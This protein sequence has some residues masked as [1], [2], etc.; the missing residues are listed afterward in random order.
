[1][2]CKQCGAPLRPNAKF[3]GICG[4]PVSDVEPAKESEKQAYRPASRENR[5]SAKVESYRPANRENRE[6]AKVE[7]YHPANRENRESTKTESYRPASRESM[8]NESYVPERKKVS[9][10]KRDI[11]EAG[12]ISSRKK[13]EKRNNQGSEVDSS[14]MKTIRKYFLS[15]RTLPMILIILG[16]PLIAAMGI[17]L[18]LI[19]IGIVMMFRS[20][21]SGEDAVDRAVNRQIHNLKKRGLDKLN[22]I[23]DQVSL[24]DPVVLIGIGSSPD[25]SFDAARMASQSRNKKGFS[26]I[27]WFLNIFRLFGKK[28]SDGTENDPVEALRIGSDDCLRTLLMEVCVYVFTEQQLLLYRGDVD[29][30]TGLVYHEMTAECFYQ[31]IEGMN[32]SQSIYKVFN[33]KKKKYMNKIM[34]SFTLF[35][36]GC[37]FSASINTEMNDSAI[38]NQFAAMRNLIRDKKNA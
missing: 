3:C 24:I 34:E 36:G 4:C 13:P 8:Q 32:F 37:N 2:N 16:I 21:F 28:K 5:E 31:D 7:S 35:L 26:N 30:S 23:Q 15:Q 29:I 6:N 20:N 38:D 10:E 14:E 19:V 22:L 25:G 17:G 1:M 18:I 27:F 9:Q 12:T 33:P 11:Y